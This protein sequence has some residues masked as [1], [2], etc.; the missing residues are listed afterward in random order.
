MH[1]CTC[2]LRKESVT[3]LLEV[4]T[5]K[6]FYQRKWSCSALLIWISS[7]VQLQGTILL[8]F[9]DVPDASRATN[10]HF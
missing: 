2:V 1:Q 8:G 4:A 6:Y 10:E 9:G 5:L 7:Q 3:R